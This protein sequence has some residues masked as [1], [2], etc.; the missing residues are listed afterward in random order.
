M[1]QSRRLSALLSGKT[2]VKTAGTNGDDR[3][4]GDDTAPFHVNWAKPI[5]TFPTKQLVE[6]GK[7]NVRRLF[8]P[9]QF[10]HEAGDDLMPIGPSPLRHMNAIATPKSVP[11]AGL[12]A[13]T[14]ES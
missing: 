2:G 13:F 8:G 9:Q 11:D 14:K 10:V 1:G 3:Q 7:G 5:G 6:R 4:I 12:G